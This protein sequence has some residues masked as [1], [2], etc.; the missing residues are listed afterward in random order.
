V[1]GELP[2]AS[3]S[4]T[5][6]A[7]ASPSFMFR[8]IYLPSIEDTPR[9]KLG[10]ELG[11]ELSPMRDGYVPTR[12]AVGTLSFNRIRIMTGARVLWNWRP[13]WMAFGRAVVGIELWDT[14]QDTHVAGLE[15]HDSS[16][17]LGFGGE[18]GGGLLWR[19][20]KLVLG[21]QL[22]VPI[23]YQPGAGAGSTTPFD[24][25]WLSVDMDVLLTVG[26]GL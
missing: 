10:I 19:S 8:G 9:F 4:Y 24:A 14:E 5:D 25:D 1:G 12:P 26:A 7:K 15:V 21:A 6:V 3:P 17:D 20:G 16:T 18:L 23:V 13:G 22:Q 11:G 2:V